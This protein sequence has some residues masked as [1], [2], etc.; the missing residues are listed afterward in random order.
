MT[1]YEEF[2]EVA[3]AVEDIYGV[4]L[5][6]DEDRDEIYGYHCPHC[7]EPV[8]FSDWVECFLGGQ[9]MNMCPICEEVL[10]VD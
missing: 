3:T 8:Y 6:I 10:G 7:G 1:L 2:R 9:D 4:P 5:I